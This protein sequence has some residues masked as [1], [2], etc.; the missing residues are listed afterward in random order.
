MGDDLLKNSIRPEALESEVSGIVEVAVYAKGREN[1]I[2]LWVGQGNQP[3]PDFITKPTM[4]SLAKGETFYGS[5]AGLID[6]RE[7]LAAYYQKHFGADWT[8]QSFYVTGSGMHAIDLALRATAGAGDEVI[9]LSPAW[10]NFVGCSTLAGIHPR[11]VELEFGANG[12]S[13]DVERIKNAINSKTK[14]IFVNTPSNPTGWAADLETLTAIRDIAR[15]HGIWIIADEIYSRFY[16]GGRRAPSF[17]DVTEPD[18][19]IIYVN[20]FSKNWAMTGW[21]LGWIA[22]NPALGTV[23]ENLIQY[24]NSGAQTFLQRGAVAALNEGDAFVQSYID[25]A[26]INRDILCAKLNATGKVKL[27]PPQGAFYLFFGIDGITDTR[28]AALKMVD[29]I[30]VGLA[31]GSAFGKGGEHYF[32]LCFLRDQQLIE[33]A[34][35]RLADWIEKQ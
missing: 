31:P 4:D 10:P 14:A 1:L 26:T 28:R 17:I 5:D 34:G 9:Y 19:R 13:L 15:E 27:V 3:T 18:D 23:I 24:S 12:W 11:A 35:D 6:T 33:E 8:P 25:Q 32:R 29:D 2:P 21:R 20:S 7:A 30:A 22:V 16:Y